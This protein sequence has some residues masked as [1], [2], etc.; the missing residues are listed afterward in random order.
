MT[1]NWRS[2]PDHRTAPTLDWVTDM[3][4]GALRRAEQWDGETEI[5][6]VFSPLNVKP[7]SERNWKNQASMLLSDMTMVVS[8]KISFGRGSAAS[9][10]LPLKEITGCT[11][12]DSSGRQLQVTHPQELVGLTFSTHEECVAIM[13]WYTE[14]R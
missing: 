1:T 7:K 4:E 2:A 11:S 8:H 9:L 10:V 12:P 3:C 6:G 14:F 5:I 13:D